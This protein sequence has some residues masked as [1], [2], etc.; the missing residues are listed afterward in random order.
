MFKIEIYSDY[1][2][3]TLE[4]KEATNG[5]YVSAKIKTKP[6]YKGGANASAAK[7]YAQENELKK[8]K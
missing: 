4:I 5:I 8:I 2:G 7:A 1:Q 6:Q 3:N